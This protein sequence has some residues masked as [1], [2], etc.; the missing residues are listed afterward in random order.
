MAF[1]AR[2]SGIVFLRPVEGEI[3]LRVTYRGTWQAQYYCSEPMRKAASGVFQQYRP[4]ADVGFAQLQSFL[5]VST[6]VCSIY[7]GRLLA[8]YGI[9]TTAICVND[10]SLPL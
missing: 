1:L 3:T 2:S 7:F 4:N 9:A 5:N 6:E 8:N 10:R